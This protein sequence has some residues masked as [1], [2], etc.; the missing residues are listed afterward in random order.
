MDLGNLVLLAAV[1]LVIV[2][3]FRVFGGPG[4]LDM[5]RRARRV[6]AR[7]QPSPALRQPTLDDLRPGDAI[8]F[9]DGQDDVV[10]SVVQ[11]RE[12]LG[13]RT[14]TWRW[15]VLSSGHVLEVAPDTNALYDQSTVLQQGSEPFYALTT[16]PEHGGALKTFEARVR[17]ESIAREPV[18]V[19]LDGKQWSVESTGTFMAA[20]LGPPP[21]QEVWRDISESPSDNV[22]FE[23][24]GEDHS[25]ALGI[26]TTH[27]LLLQGRPLEESDIQSLYPG[28]EERTG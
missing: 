25:S 26:W 1:I 27:I 17:D 21:E 13:G 4:G 19:T 20:Y 14:S 12:E 15:V 7:E 6:L 22:Y 3:A 5:F 24:R 2:I 23:L 16:E 10:E 18:S 11:S 28:G 8:S 9:W